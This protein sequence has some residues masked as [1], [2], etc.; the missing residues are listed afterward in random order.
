MGKIKIY[1]IAKKLG[2]T[3]KEVLD[4][5]KK[6]N[7][8]AKSHLSGVEEDEAKK[9]ESELS[10]KSEKGNSDKAKSEEKAAKKVN[11]DKNKNEKRRNEIFN[12]VIK[13]IIRNY[14]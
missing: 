13:R 3:S 14:A 1:D 4:I 2:L 9:I 7:I 8:E 12:K 10:N 11:A 6:L 5:A